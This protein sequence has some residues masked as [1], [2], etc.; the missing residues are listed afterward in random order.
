MD[1]SNYKGV[2]AVIKYI[3]MFYS[4]NKDLFSLILP[5]PNKSL[6]DKK[7]TISLF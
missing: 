3:G 4:M 7:N 1:S 2:Q 6:L 5:L